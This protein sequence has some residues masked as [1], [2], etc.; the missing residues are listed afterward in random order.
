[1]SVNSGLDRWKKS[2]RPYI[3]EVPG[4]LLDDHSKNVERLVIRD[5]VT[6]DT[7]VGGSS[8]V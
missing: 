2:S 5:Y 4:P 6:V 1:M 8:R 3:V 7:E